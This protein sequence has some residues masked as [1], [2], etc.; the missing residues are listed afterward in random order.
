MDQ[1]WLLPEVNYQSVWEVSWKT[2]IPADYFLPLLTCLLFTISLLIWIYKWILMG[3][4]CWTQ[5]LQGGT[6]VERKMNVCNSASFPLC[7][8]NWDC[9][10]CFL[11]PLCPSHLF[12]LV[13]KCFSDNSVEPRRCAARNVSVRNSS[14]CSQYLCSLD[15]S[16]WFSNFLFS[17]F[18]VLA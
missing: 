13:L 10:W 18:T 4:Y 2:Y 16:Y 8:E 15:C 17:Y 6:T 9:F 11:G 3:H 14:Y 1:R 5:N 12:W 7:L